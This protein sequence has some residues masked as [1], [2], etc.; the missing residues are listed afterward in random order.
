MITSGKTALHRRNSTRNV[1]Y[2]D[3]YVILSFILKTHY[4]IINCL[5]KKTNSDVM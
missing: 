3:K 1:K 5:I 4:K 2:V